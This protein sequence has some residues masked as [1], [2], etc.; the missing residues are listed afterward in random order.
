M[1]E[2]I[3]SQGIQADS[4]SLKGQENEFFPRASRKSAALHIHL[5]PWLPELQDNK[6]VFFYATKFVG[7]CHN[8]NGN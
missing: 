7:T 1:K 8:T 2:G 4:S 6:S 3:M 5:D